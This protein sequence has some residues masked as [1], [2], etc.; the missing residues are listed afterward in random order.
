MKKFLIIGIILILLSGLSLFFYLNKNGM[1]KK[2]STRLYEITGNGAK[3]SD[4]N[5]YID[6][7]YIVTNIA[8]YKKDEKNSFYVIFADNVQFIVYLS[9]SDAK[10][11]NNYLLDNPDK[12]YRIYGITKKMPSDIKEYGKVFLKTYLD[13]NH[14]HEEKKEHN[15]TDEDFDKYFGFVYLNCQEKNYQIYYYLTFILEIF[16]I[17]MILDYIYLKLR[18]KHENS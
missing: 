17:V 16:G 1:I 5:A 3:T 2:N 18:R 6:A 15:V 9:N 11:I 4:V 12:T 7:S 10:K 8:N 13:N 14:V